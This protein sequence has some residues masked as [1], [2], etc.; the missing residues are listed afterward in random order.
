MGGWRSII[1]KHY[2]ILYEKLEHLRIWGCGWRWGWG[3][4]PSPTVGGATVYK[5]I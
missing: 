4:E 5:F 1:C 2:T 3:P